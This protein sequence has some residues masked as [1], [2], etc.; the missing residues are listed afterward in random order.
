MLFPCT[1]VADQM[2]EVKVPLSL[3]VRV[4]WP[5]FPH[6]ESYTCVYSVNG[7]VKDR[8]GRMGGCMDSPQKAELCFNITVM[9]LWVRKPQVADQGGRHKHCF[10]A[11]PESSVL[12]VLFKN[13]QLKDL[14]YV[15]SLKSFLYKQYFLINSLTM[16]GSFSLP[17]IHQEFCLSHGHL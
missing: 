3:R 11:F 15:E 2:A 4:Q 7:W 6:L 1:F 9:C 16:R 12:R 14:A 5:R 13:L 10:T 8:Q 17:H